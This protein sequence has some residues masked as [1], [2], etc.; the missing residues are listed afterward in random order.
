MEKPKKKKRKSKIKE[1]NISPEKEEI[2]VIKEYE[3]SDNIS[4]NVSKKYTK[5]K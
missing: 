5:K 1:E 2:N 3:L 4:D